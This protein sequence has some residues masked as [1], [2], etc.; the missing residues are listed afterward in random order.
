MTKERAKAR[1]AQYRDWAAR[2]KEK[3]DELHAEIEK[4]MQNSDYSEPI[5][6]DHHSC[7]KH[8]RKFERRDNMMRRS[9]ELEQK[10]DSHLSKAKNLD[11]FANKIA[12]DA[13][14][15]RQKQRNENDSI[16]EVGRA[17]YDHCFKWGV[18]KKINKK[19]YT[20]QFDS[21]VT[22]TRDKSF[23]EVE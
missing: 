20:I 11:I 3:L 22:M 1:A 13:E 19:T 5:K 6:Y 14:R 16:A 17:V 4:D 21:G 9:I 18:I 8:A 7:I 23:V 15:E 10:I 2:A 12:G